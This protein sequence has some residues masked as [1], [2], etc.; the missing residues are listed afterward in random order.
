[1]L[2]KKEILYFVFVVSLIFTFSFILANAPGWQ[3]QDVNY[4]VVEDTSYNHN[5][6]LNITNYAGDVNFTID[7]D[8][9]ITWINASG[10]NSIAKAIVSSWIFP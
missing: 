10:S 1:M 5:L 2:S 8:S 7:S 6:T 4:S 9:D 3:G